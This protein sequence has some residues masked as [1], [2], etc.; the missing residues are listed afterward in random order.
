MQV[1]VRFCVIK[2]QVTTKV[3]PQS[4]VQMVRLLLLNLRRVAEL[5]LLDLVLRCILDLRETATH[6]VRGFAPRR[7]LPKRLKQP[8]DLLAR[9]RTGPGARGYPLPERA[10]F[11][12]YTWELTTALRK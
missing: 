8:L 11:A 2:T 12:L 7:V 3:V 5:L 6:P 1:Q 4:I 10:P 9:T